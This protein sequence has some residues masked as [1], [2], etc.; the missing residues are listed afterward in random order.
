[1]VVVK[2]EVNKEVNE[3]ELAKK[4]LGKEAPTKKAELEVPHWF[5]YVRAMILGLVVA[6]WL[7][8]LYTFVTLK[9]HPTVSNY[10]NFITAL[11]GLIITGGLLTAVTSRN[12]ITL[13]MMMEKKPVPKSWELS[14]YMTA[15]APL[16]AVVIAVM[17]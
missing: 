17:L 10:G 5:L 15:A 7:G 13:K 9:A 16:V 12:Y 3:E 14:F 11:R 1:M 2:K 6:F 8:L 4:L